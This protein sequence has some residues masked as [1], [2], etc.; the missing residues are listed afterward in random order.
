MFLESVHA[1][2]QDSLILFER[3]SNIQKQGADAQ[4][5]RAF[6]AQFDDP[7]TEHGNPE[8]VERPPL[9]LD[10]SRLPF[11]QTRT[12][13]GPLMVLIIDDHPDTRDSLA[14]CLSM[15]GYGVFVA[16]SR[17]DGVTILSQQTEIHCV[18]L[19]YNMP[20]MSC[21]DFLSIVRRDHAQ[22]NCIL[23]SAGSEIR[24]I[25]RSLGVSDWIRKP[26]DFDSL[27]KLVAKYGHLAP[28]TKMP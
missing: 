7:T 13:G 20:G 27:F 18:L 3:T 11:V 25:A 1:T 19:D 16:A 24:E 8:E 4:G 14:L 10:V 2:R 21:Q 6:S 22:A 9:L 5:R 17:E 12:T 23:M 28:P 15:Q 26:A